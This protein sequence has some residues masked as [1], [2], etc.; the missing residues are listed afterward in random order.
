MI[1]VL[2]ALAPVVIFAIV[3]Y[4]WH[5]V[6]VELL[7]V[8]TMCLAEFVFVL[9]KNWGPKDGQKHSLKEKFSTAIKGYGINNFLVPCVS[10][11]IFAM[12]MPAQ[13]TNPSGFIYFVVVIGALF[14]MNYLTILWGVLVLA[15]LSFVLGIAMVIAGKFLHVEEDPR[16]A[17]VEKLLPNGN[18][19]AC[20]F[21]GC[22]GRRSDPAHIEGSGGAVTRGHRRRVGIIGILIDWWVFLIGRGKNLRNRFRCREHG[23]IGTPGEMLQGEE[24]AVIGIVSASEEV[25]IAFLLQVEIDAISRHLIIGIID[26]FDSGGR[27]ADF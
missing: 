5:A 2:I 15:G 10:A 14:G 16:I 13:E 19:G 26:A 7:S 11:V 9:I 18:C 23:R 6:V 8:F 4:S 12:L 3:K 24:C 1:D 20:G 25:N 27:R 22:H 17:D 21:P